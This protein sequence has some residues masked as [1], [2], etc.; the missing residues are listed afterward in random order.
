MVLA[1]LV[2]IRLSRKSTNFFT[3]LSVGF[4]FIRT[5]LESVVSKSLLVGLKLQRW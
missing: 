3:P 4:S 1:A 2:L 5:A